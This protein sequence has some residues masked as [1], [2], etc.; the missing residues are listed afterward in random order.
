MSNMKR[1]WNLEEY[2]KIDSHRALQIDAMHS[3][4]HKMFGE[5]S[6]S[7]ESNNDGILSPT[8]RVKYYNLKE[9]LSKIRVAHIHA[10]AETIELH[11]FRISA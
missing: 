8:E 6:E 1:K 11:Y 5:I 4:L 7:S 9:K 2:L 3:R 10:R